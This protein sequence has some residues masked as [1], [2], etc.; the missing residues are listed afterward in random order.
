M[1]GNQ[2]K[3]RIDLERKR[4]AVFMRGEE[5]VFEFTVDCALHER[6]KFVYAIIFPG[7]ARFRFY[8]RFILMRIAQLIDYPPI[9]VIL[10]R[11][12]GVKIGKGVFISPDVV[13]DTH[14]PHLIEIG[15]YA[16]LGWG[17]FLFNHE[18]SGNK[19]RM[20]R[21]KIGEGAV[22][23]GFAGIRGGVNIG[24]GVDVPASCIVYKDLPHSACLNSLVLR[25][26]AIPE[27][28]GKEN[29][30]N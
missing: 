3:E 21:I 30:G 29:H 15:D 8:A 14:F 26:R 2:I 9:K 17:A 20:G 4:L 27:V 1:S 24:D 11:F 22:I 19:Y 10:Y 23:G 25:K 12:I 6:I 18:F 16:I 7:L 5:S 28:Y 13:I